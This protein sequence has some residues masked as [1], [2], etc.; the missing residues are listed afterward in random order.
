MD[1]E[2][3]FGEGLADDGE[4]R[5]V[6]GGA[7]GFGLTTWR[8]GKAGEGRKSGVLE[9]FLHGFG[10]Q[11]GH[12]AGNEE[13][14]LVA[15][16]RRKGAF[17]AAEGAL[18]GVSFDQAGVAEVGV[19]IGRTEEGGGACG[20]FDLA[21]DGLRESRAGVGEQ[22]LVGPHAAAAAASEHEAS[23]PHETILAAGRGPEAGL[24]QNTICLQRMS[25]YN[26]NKL[27]AICFSLVAGA[28]LARGAEANERVTTT[29]KAD[30]RTGRLVRSTVAAKPVQKPLVKAA[31]KPQAAPTSGLEAPKVIASKAPQTVAPRALPSFGEPRDINAIIEQTAAANSVDPLLVHSVIRAE[32]NYNPYAVSPKGAEGIM[33]L[34]PATAKRF[35]AQNSFDVRDNIEAGVKYLKYLQDL[36]K[37]DRLAV[38]AYNAGEGAVIRYGDVPPYRETEQ[39]VNR[40]GKTY[41]DAKKKLAPAVAP[42][43]AAPVVPAPEPMRQLDLSTD[44]EGRLVL[45]SK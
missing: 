2:A 34:I 17:E 8:G 45:R 38:A 39:Y 20:E 12:I 40:V 9:H 15:G 24:R 28:A 41:G 26:Q 11:N 43:A 14:P 13:S 3:V 19:K 32:S 44:A 6:I 37:D 5:G 33:Q 16:E 29:V 22:G 18:A 1:G 25:R 36:F 4:E 30:P 21:G 31:V 42:V 35:G 23:G 7:E 27:M 10:V